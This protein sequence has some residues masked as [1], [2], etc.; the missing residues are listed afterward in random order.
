MKKF[1]CRH[2]VD[3]IGSKKVMIKLGFEYVSDS[4]YTSFS[5]QKHFLSK[6]YYLGVD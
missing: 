5:G 1:L 4:S 6:E 2:A 3:N